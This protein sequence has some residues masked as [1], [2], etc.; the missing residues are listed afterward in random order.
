MILR[1][2][3]EVGSRN[4]TNVEREFLFKFEEIAENAYHYL[5]NRGYLFPG[6]TTQSLNPQELAEYNRYQALTDD[7]QGDYNDILKQEW[8][9]AEFEDLLVTTYNQVNGKELI[10]NL[11]L[12]LVSL[13][14]WNY[15]NRNK[16]NHLLHYDYCR[17]T[18]SLSAI[19]KFVKENEMFSNSKVYK[20]KRNMLK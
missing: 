12:K 18:Q 19:T 17:I 9:D 6:R 5:G 2:S 16:L 7:E 14:L 13:N 10:N 11:Y 8:L 1:N 3:T 4:L 15:K 20:R